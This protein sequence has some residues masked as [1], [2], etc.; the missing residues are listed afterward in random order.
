[1][2]MYLFQKQQYSEERFRLHNPYSLFNFL[3]FSI[4]S[5]MYLWMLQQS[6][7]ILYFIY[8]FILYFILNM[9]YLSLVLQRLFKCI[10][11]QE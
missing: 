5:V 3:S 9:A 6:G 10:T 4:Q 8:L 1:M 11:T 7:I 2:Y